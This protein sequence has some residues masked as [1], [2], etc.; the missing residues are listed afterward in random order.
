MRV[1]EVDVPT[2]SQYS[3]RRGEKINS[4]LHSLKGDYVARATG[5]VSASY[6]FLLLFPPDVLGWTLAERSLPLAST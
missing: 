1:I 5:R 6:N 4:R 3:Q 2:R